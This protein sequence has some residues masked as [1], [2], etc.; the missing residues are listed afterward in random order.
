MGR[1]I[2][3]NAK[4]VRRGSDE[5]RQGHARLAILQ[6]KRDMR[7]GHAQLDNACTK[8]ERYA[9]GPRMQRA[10]VTAVLWVIFPYSASHLIRTC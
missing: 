1:S 10:I 3:R 9:V 5:A 8:K 6:K 2:T 7:Q 4:S